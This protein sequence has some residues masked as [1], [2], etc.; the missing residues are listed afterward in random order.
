M[1]RR[2]SVLLGNISVCSV[3]WNRSS[4]PF[5]AG[6]SSSP[7]AARPPSGSRYSSNQGR[8][9]SATARGTFGLIGV[10]L[11]RR[12]VGGGSKIRIRFTSR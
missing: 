1:K 8:V 5:S 9:P 3:S 10:G 7:P 11:V 2:H 4:L 12:P 6:V